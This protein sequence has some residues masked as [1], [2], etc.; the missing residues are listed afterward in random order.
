MFP[1]QA[2]D[3]EGRKALVSSLS[4]TMPDREAAAA[5]AADKARAVA[6]RLARAERGEDVGG[7]GKRMTRKELLVAIG[8]KPADLRH[9]LGLVEI[10]ERGAHADLMDE[11]MKRHRQTEKPRR[12]RSWHGN[13]V[14]PPSRLSPPLPAWGLSD[15][16]RRWHWRAGP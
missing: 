10:E 4:R 3:I 15:S 13:G 7:I 9:A 1:G 5:D 6:E 16:L 8:W 14:R 12:V 2:G 11:I